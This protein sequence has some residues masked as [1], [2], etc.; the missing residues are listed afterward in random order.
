MRMP[1]LLSKSDSGRFALGCDLLPR[2]IRST[3]DGVVSLANL[4]VRGFDTLKEVLFSSVIHDLS[5][6]R[7]RLSLVCHKRKRKRVRSAL[8][9]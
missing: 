2:R 8:K 3:Y 6:V 1:M 9:Q 7:P 4:L 5:N